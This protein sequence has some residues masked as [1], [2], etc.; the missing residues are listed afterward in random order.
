MSASPQPQNPLFWHRS[1]QPGAAVQQFIQA[2]NQVFF[3]GTT[4][5]VN[6][7]VVEAIANQ[8]FIPWEVYQDLY[9][10]NP[11][12]LTQAAYPPAWQAVYL[13]LRHQ[14]E[15]QYHSLLR[16][17]ASPLYDPDLLTAGPENLPPLPAPTG[18]KSEIQRLRYLLGDRQFLC[19]L[20]KMGELKSI[21]DQRWRQCQ[22]QGETA[23]DLA[24]PNLIYAKTVLQLDGTITNTYT[25]ALM[26]HPH[27]GLILQAHQNNIQIGDQQWR[28]FLSFLVGLVHSSLKRPTPKRRS[29]KSLSAGSS[30]T[31]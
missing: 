19:C 21:L 29:P 3:A 7:M 11:Q 12:D 20:R 30:P 6:T 24:P 27:C 2:L 16:E 17:P 22:R 4:L 5:E 23:P 8:R 28:G 26:A 1:P 14:L 31:L 13:D 10:L 25:E 9:Q 18:A 15:R